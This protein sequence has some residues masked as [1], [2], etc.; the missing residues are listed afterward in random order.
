MGILRTILDVVVTTGMGEMAKEAAKQLT[1]AK[2]SALKKT[3][4]QV[5]GWLFGAMLADKTV[6]HTCKVVKEFFSDMKE[7]DVNDEPAHS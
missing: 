7:E 3:C 5:S 4:I 6:E 2:A 1:P